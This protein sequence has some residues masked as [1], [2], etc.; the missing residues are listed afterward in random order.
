MAEAARGAE[1]SEVAQG[2]GEIGAGGR[3]DGSRR[4]RRQLGE[5]RTAM[6]GC[7]RR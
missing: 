5:P 2:G 3:R 4:W 7:G 6:G 1:D